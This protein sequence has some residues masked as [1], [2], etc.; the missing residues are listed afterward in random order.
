MTATTPI[1]S[2]YSITWPLLPDDFVLPDDPVENEA[3]PLLA[4]ALTQALS[5]QPAV[6]KDA[7]I[8]SNFALCAGINR[9][10]ICKAP[11]WMYVAPVPPSDRIRRSYTPHTEGVVPP[12][13][14][15]FLS[16]RDCG[17]YSMKPGRKI[18]K[19]YFYERIIEVPRYVI[20]D[21]DSAELEVYA[22][23]D[24]RYELETADEQGR[25]FI[26]GLDLFLGVWEGTHEVRTGPWLRWWTAAGELVPWSEER[27]QQAQVQVQQAQVQAQQAEARAQQA[28]QEKAAL[29]AKLRAAGLE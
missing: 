25:Y 26:P 6:I 29:L 16:E 1:T 4:A 12:V 5:S 7:L 28:E 3:Q 20:F 23:Q 9:Q 24:N 14:M 8:V 22:L 17:E 19:W 18:G 15:E 10:I 13:V 11:D 21:P 2:P 27:V